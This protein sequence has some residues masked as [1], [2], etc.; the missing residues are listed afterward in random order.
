[1]NFILHHDKNEKIVTKNLSK[2]AFA[3]SRKFQFIFIQMSVPA[4]KILSILRDSIRKLLK[5]RRDPK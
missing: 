1:V 4:P 5:P 2:A 3:K